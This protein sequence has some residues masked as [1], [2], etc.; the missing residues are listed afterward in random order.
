MIQRQRRIP[1]HLR[2]KVDCE[3]NRLEE[4]TWISSVHNVPKKDDKIHLCVD[5]RAANI[6]I[7]EYAILFQQYET[8]PIPGS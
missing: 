4:T 7:K 1:F 8:F 5:M 3:L 6:A 2:P